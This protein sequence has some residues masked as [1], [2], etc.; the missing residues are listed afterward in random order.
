MNTSTDGAADRPT[1]SCSTELVAA[2]ASAPTPGMSGMLKIAPPGMYLRTERNQPMNLSL[3]SRAVGNHSIT[4]I[5]TFSRAVSIARPCPLT[6]NELQKA[7]LDRCNVP[8][9]PV[10]SFSAG[11]ISCS[12]DF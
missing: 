3:N 11:V 1:L 9:K 5:S 6:G 2:D 7:S 12:P 8:M 10:N 4:S